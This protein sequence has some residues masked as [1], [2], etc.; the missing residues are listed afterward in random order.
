ML[1]PTPTPSLLIRGTRL[2]GYGLRCPLAEGR[3][4]AAYALCLLAVSCAS[5]VEQ[6]VVLSQ[7]AAKLMAS[8]SALEIGRLRSVR[9]AAALEASTT[10]AELAA[11][12]TVAEAATAVAAPDTPQAAAA[13][14]TPQAAAAAQI[15]PEAAAG[16][17]APAAAPAPPVAAAPAPAAPAAPAAPVARPA[18]APD[19]APIA[20]ASTAAPPAPTGAG[21]ASAPVARAPAAR[22]RPA[23]TAPAPVARRAERPAAPPQERPAAAPKPTP[24]ASEPTRRAEPEPPA[25]AAGGATVEP[26]LDATDLYYEGKRKLDAGKRDE[27]IALLN[28]SLQRRASDRTRALLGRALFDAGRYGEAEKALRGATEHPDA[29]LLLAQLYQHQGKASEARRTYTAFLTHHPNHAKA[30]WVRGMLR[31]L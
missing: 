6:E 11:A 25:A 24:P 16:P 22:V 15:P 31:N 13:P 29:L 7:R 9:S 1:T 12:A 3:R 10:G 2:A 4:A 20:A 30:E 14:D 19:A 18:A 28:A 17:A 23:A 26:G 27:A 8:P 5:E 21:P